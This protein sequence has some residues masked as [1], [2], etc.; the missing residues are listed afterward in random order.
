MILSNITNM[1]RC[2][3]SYVK[4]NITGISIDYE[5]LPFDNLA[6]SEWIQPRIID[7]Y[8]DRGYRDSEVKQSSTILYQI[9]VFVKNSGATTSDRIYAIRDMIDVWFKI[10]ANINYVVSGNTLALARVRE[11]KNDFP[12]SDDNELSQYVLAYD[13]DYNEC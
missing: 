10:G 6:V 8:E 11:L 1:K 9:N 3:D 7:A 5:G 12:I 4:T 2:F 13:L